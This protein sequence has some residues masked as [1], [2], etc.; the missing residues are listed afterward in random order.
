[1]PDAAYHGLVRSAAETLRRRC[2]V[3][4]GE[5]LLL[6]VSGGADSVALLRALHGLA[7]RR[8]WRLR[9]TVGHVN[10]ALRHGSD[11][12]AAFVRELAQTLGLNCLERTLDL[13][14]VT[15]N[16]EA[17]A[18]DARYAALHEMAD[19]AQ[20]ATI[21]VAHHGDDQLETI[22]MRLLRGSSIA[23]LAGMDWRRDRIVRPLLGVDRP[24]IEDYLHALGQSW[25]EDP[26][27]DDVSLTRNLIRR[28]WLPMLRRIQPRMARRMTQLSDHLRGLAA[29]V[30]SVTQRCTPP[31][32]HLDRNVARR[33]FPLLLSAVLRRMI[34]RSGVGADRISHATLNR[35]V[36]AAQDHHGGQR[37]F[38]LA[39]GCSVTVT[40]ESLSV[41]RGDA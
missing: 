16:L 31:G 1:M 3:R 5:H 28:D 12:D 37:R 6:A 33:M 30:E 23:G 15:D 2:G 39:D 19:E 36:L 41:Q 9:L 4:E 18:R 22:L 34:E 21:A 11:Q 10:H 13:S 29:W 8:R 32:D 24:T 25:R 38:D 26:T 17:A 7:L 35:I 27:N 14:G 20:A 40:S